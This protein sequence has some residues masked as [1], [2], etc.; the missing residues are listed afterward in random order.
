MPR[1]TLPLPEDTNTNIR[2]KAS[3]A[4]QGISE[5]I[6][7]AATQGAKAKVEKKKS[8]KQPAEDENWWERVKKGIKKALEIMRSKHNLR[9]KDSKRMDLKGRHPNSK[10][11]FNKNTQIRHGYPHVHD[12]NIPGGVRDPIPQDY[13]EINELY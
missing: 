8:K 10:G 13:R 12:P 1:P 11:H 4:Q 6:T 9:L 5:S 3:R 7:H 2:N